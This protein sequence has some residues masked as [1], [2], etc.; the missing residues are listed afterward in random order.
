MIL[1]GNNK[2]MA[3]EDHGSSS[4]MWAREKKSALKGEPDHTL[5][6]KDADLWSIFSGKAREAAD[7]SSRTMLSMATRS[8]YNKFFLQCS[9]HVSLILSLFLSFPGQSPKWV[10]STIKDL[11]N[12]KCKQVCPNTVTSP[13][14]VPH[15]LQIV[16]S[17]SL[18][19][20][21]HPAKNDPS[22][23]QKRPLICFHGPFLSVNLGS[24]STRKTLEIR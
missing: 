18:Q 14:P 17:K 13:L 19:P 10:P 21:I 20:S 5:Q 7:H 1:K 3:M 2:Y 6:G 24:S 9:S 23:P 11:P 22:S 4:R 15:E 12:S 8:F 16:T